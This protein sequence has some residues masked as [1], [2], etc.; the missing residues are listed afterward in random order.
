RG[1]IGHEDGR[2]HHERPCE[3]DALLFAAGELHGVMF[4]PRVEA[5]ADQE[6]ARPLDGAIGAVR[7][8]SG[9]HDVL[10]GGKGGNQMVRLKY[11]ADFAAADHSQAI[12]FEARDVLAIEHDS[13]GGGGIEPGEQAEKRAFAAARRAHNCH[14]LPGRDFEIDAFEDVDAVRPV[15]NGSREI[16]DRDNGAPDGEFL[17]LLL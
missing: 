15:N 2:M 7:E 6:L 1:F 14:E 8:F 17:S 12:L 10:L 13:P 11:E 5:D 9:Q 3:S 16:A 4:A